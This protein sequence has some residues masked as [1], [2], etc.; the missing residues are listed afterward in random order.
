MTIETLADFIIRRRREIAEAQDRLRVELDALDKEFEQ[1]DKA[2]RAAGIEENAIATERYRENNGF[3][4]V[5]RTRQKVVAEK[6]I[7]EAVVEILKDA[8]HGMTALEILPKVNQRLG[9]DYPRTSLSPQLSRLKA[10]GILVR[11]GIAWSLAQAPQTE[12]APTAAA[13]GAS[14]PET[15]EGSD[16][17]VFS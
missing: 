11:D 13:E 7:K 2:A 1:I 15:A 14:K 6:T 5:E 3:F 9:V 10:D 16:L 17:S 8:G 12:K 4:A